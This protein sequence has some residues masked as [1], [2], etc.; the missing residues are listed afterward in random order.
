MM[1]ALLHPPHV[2]TL[3]PAE[4]HRDRTSLSLSLSLSRAWRENFI[5]PNSLRLI[6]RRRSAGSLP[7]A[8]ARTCTH[9]CIGQSSSLVY[10]LP[11]IHYISYASHN[12]T[13]KLKGLTRRLDYAFGKSKGRLIAYIYACV[14]HCASIY[15]SRTDRSFDR[16]RINLSG[17]SPS[18]SRW[19][20]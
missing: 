3:T 10:S 2:Y 9:P 15:K 18:R 8:A 17:R 16:H 5:W 19:R 14:F 12:N 4:C 20:K 1:H 13:F 6:T 11:R 7:R